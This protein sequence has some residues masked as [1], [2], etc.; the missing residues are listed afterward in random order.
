MENS[1]VTEIE[2]PRYKHRESLKIATKNAVT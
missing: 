2:E 1:N